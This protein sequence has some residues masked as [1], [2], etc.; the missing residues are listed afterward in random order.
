V[1]IR[2]IAW[3]RSVNERV[4]RGDPTLRL[5]QAL[6]RLTERLRK[7]SSSPRLDAELIAMQVLGCPRTALYGHPES[8]LDDDQ[9]TRI[10]ELGRRRADGEPIA[11]LIG[12]REFWSLDLEVTPATLVPRPDTE[13]LVEIAL[14]C[15]PPDRP[16]TVADLGT[17]CGAVALAIASERPLASIVATDLD[18]AALEVAR[19]NVRRPG[20]ANVTLRH[21]DWCAA[22]GA[23][24]FDLIVSN[25]PYV[26]DADPWLDPDSARYEPRLALAGGRDGLRCITL[27]A[28]QAR[29][30][31]RAGGRLLLEH[32]FDQAA[33]VA[34]LLAGLGYRTPRGY[35]DAAGQERVTAAQ[36]PTPATP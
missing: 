34:A 9:W 4:A 30:H 1:K 16:V 3:P 33:A 5:D 18:R 10:T 15:L 17:G 32:G 35:R 14:A 7:R 12:H 13:R 24:R 27:I 21:G 11:Y 8:R 36:W 29:D 2:P 28:D 31:L 23:R 26:R 20:L 25:P 6:S 22:L 19:R